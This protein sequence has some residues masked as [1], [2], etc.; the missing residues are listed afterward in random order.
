MGPWRGRV[1]EQDHTGPTLINLTHHTLLAETGFLRNGGDALIEHS[2]QHV[3]Y[4][5]SYTPNHP[6]LMRI[7]KP[8]PTSF[9]LKALSFPNNSWYVAKAIV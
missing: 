2:H 5:F 6:Q 7:R 1:G 4:P 9:F 3:P 8:L